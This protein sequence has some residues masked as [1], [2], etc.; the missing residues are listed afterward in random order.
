MTKLSNVS[1][2]DQ[3]YQANLSRLMQRRILP[4]RYRAGQ[5]VAQ[6]MLHKSADRGGI[7]LVEMLVVVAIIGMLAGL[8]L[9]A[10]QSARESA[11]SMG[12][13]NNLKQIGLAS[14]NYLSAH[15]R[16]PPSFCISLASLSDR[17][18]H[19]WS[20]HAR[21][22]PFL[23][24][25]SAADQIRLDVDWHLQVESG[26]TAWRPGVYACSS[27]PNQEI[28]LKDGRPY[29]ASV[30]YGFVAG[31]WRVF[32]PE[33]RRGG[34]GAFI[35]NGNLSDGKISDGFDN[36]LAVS[37]VKTYQPYVRNAESVGAFPPVDSGVFRRV[38]GQFKTTGHTV[39]PDGRVHHTGITTSFV[40]NTFVPYD[41]G[42]ERNL[43]RGFW[44]IDYT[45]QQEGK[46]SSKTTYAAITAR[47]YHVGRVN[48][49]M[50]SGRVISV[51]DTIDRSAYQSLGTRSGAERLDPAS[52]ADK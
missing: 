24:Q 33:N 23:E 39:W 44:D 51:S 29:V 5:S 4:T 2:A 52:I 49:V 45:S 42:D 18:A 10:V 27:E 16:L 22:L 43:G 3:L 35:V 47:S 9:P 1:S 34:D 41:A 14:Q 7:S 11:R 31:T 20:V 19:S 28:R 40:P 26:L 50:L 46:S 30:N 48:A 15:R 6:Q 36:T 37:E 12:C 21:L 8:L 13:Q 32:S 17:A 38:V 25:A